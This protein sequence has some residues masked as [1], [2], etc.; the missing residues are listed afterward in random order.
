MDIIWLRRQFCIVRCYCHNQHLLGPGAST[1]KAQKKVDYVVLFSTATSS[2]WIF[3]INVGSPC[4]GL[5]NM[6]NVTLRCFG[7]LSTFPP[8]YEHN[9]PPQNFQANILVVWS[10]FT[11]ISTYAMFWLPCP[12]CRSRI[13]AWS[14]Q[15]VASTA[16]VLSFALLTPE[17]G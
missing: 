5:D 9:P 1:A 13:L 6:K 12:G 11:A 4:V 14:Q 3:A 15:L 17:S 10:Y 8:L 7:P 2:A 16:H